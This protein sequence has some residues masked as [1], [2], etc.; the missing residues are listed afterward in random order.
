MGVREEGR[1]AGGALRRC[2]ERVRGG[3]TCSPCGP[4]G[5]GVKGR[6]RGGLDMQFTPSSKGVCG[7]G[8]AVHAVL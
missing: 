8:H 2:V 4:E 3:G 1:G 6:G 7:G 5:G